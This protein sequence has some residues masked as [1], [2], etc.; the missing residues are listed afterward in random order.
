MR[1][2]SLFLEEDTK[3]KVTTLKVK[4]FEAEDFVLNGKQNAPSEGAAIC[5]SQK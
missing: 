5:H 1:L 4:P 3:V 2:G